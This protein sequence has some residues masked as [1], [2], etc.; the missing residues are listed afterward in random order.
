MH[1][2]NILFYFAVESPTIQS[3]QTNPCLSSPCGLNADCQ[4]S[5][6]SYT[7]SCL[8]EFIGNP[9]N[10]KAECSSN[11]ECANHLACLI[12]SCKDP[13][14]IGICG[15]NAKCHVINHFPICECPDNYAGDPYD[16]CSLKEIIRAEINPCSNRPCGLNAIC[17]ERNGAGVCECL[18]HHYGDPH[19]MCRHECNYS[20]D[21]L[22]NHACVQNKCTDACA[23]ACGENAQ[24]LVI[25]HVPYCSCKSG[26]IG[27]PLTSCTPLTIGKFISYLA[28]ELNLDE[29]KRTR[30]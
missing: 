22:S 5:G 15:Q 27:N 28:T 7:C 25:E 4:L 10:C 23:N 30:Y 19:E 6:S 24:C 16:K 11:S 14:A 12:Q 13:C 8:P 18:P 29:L 20:S 2:L 26:F 3:K 17:Q 1:H 9:P 21:C